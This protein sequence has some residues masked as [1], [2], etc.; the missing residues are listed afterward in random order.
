MTRKRPAGGLLGP[1][2]PP[3]DPFPAL[4]EAATRAR[5]VIA[6]A[7]RRAG[8]LETWADAA[9]L[10]RSD[11]LTPDHPFSRLFGFERAKVLLNPELEPRRV[12]AAEKRAIVE[13][14]SL[15]GRPVRDIA[16]ATGLHYTY[17]VKIRARL[18]DE[19]RLPPL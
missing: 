12:K 8:L 15:A 7:R 5:A 14:L 1:L 11:Q 16:D 18:R 3:L 2:K 10:P 6:E 13:T 9:L 17:V 19:G 4:G